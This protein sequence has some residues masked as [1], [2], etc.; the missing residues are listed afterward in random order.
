MQ[1]SKTCL[2]IE[3]EAGCSFGVLVKFTKAFGGCFIYFFSSH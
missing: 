1:Q 2:K 3:P